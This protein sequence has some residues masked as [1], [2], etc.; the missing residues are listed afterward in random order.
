[1]RNYFAFKKWN[2]ASLY[3]RDLKFYPPFNAFARRK[4]NPLDA[5]NPINFYLRI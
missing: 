1:M 4:V 2:V 5:S 3:A